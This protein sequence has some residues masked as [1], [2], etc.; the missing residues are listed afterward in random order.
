M[1][2]IGSVTAIILYPILY[3]CY[4]SPVYQLPAGFSNA[5]NLPIEGQLPKADAAQAKYAHIGARPTA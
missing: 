5:R 4:F 2:A 1:S 3:L